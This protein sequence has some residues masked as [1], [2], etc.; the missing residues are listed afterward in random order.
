[1]KTKIVS[2]CSL[3]NMIIDYNLEQLYFKKLL[4][5]LTILQ[6]QLVAIHINYWVPKI[7]LISLISI[8]DITNLISLSP[9]FINHTN[10]MIL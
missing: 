9:K 7:P 10:D 5:L 1:M 3:V 4:F 2:S 6:I 8:V